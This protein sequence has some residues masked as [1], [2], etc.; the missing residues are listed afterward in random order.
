MTDI[1]QAP[2]GLAPIGP[3]THAPGHAARAVAAA[4]GIALGVVA[5][6]AVLLYLV[7]ALGGLGVVIAAVAA[8]I[9]FV[10]VLLTIRWIDRWEPEP[11]P[12]LVFAVLW[13]AGVAVAV[14]LLFD[15]GVQVVLAVAGGRP[16]DFAQAVV[17]APIV[18]EA[19]KG[20]GVLLLFWVNRRHF[21]GPVDGIVYAASI[22][23]GFAFTENILYFGRVI[24]E[25]GL[26]A[27]F[28]FTFVVRGIFSPFAHVLFT[29]CT[30]FAIGR[31]AER[32]GG[33]AAGFGAYVLGLIPAAFLHALWN[34]GLS[35]AGNVIEYYLLVEFPIFLGAVAVV[36]T[37]RARERAVTRARLGEYA[38]AGW[39][40]PQEVALISTPGG[41]RQ[42][43]RW[44]QAQPDPRRKRE[45]MIRLVRDATRLGHARQRLVKGRATIGR[46]P[47]EQELLARIT[48]DRA[49]LTS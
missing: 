31:I 34:G 17:Q 2:T 45:A 14:A 21:D 49:V 7:S 13:G 24:A 37:V 41:R 12:A 35:L 36:L 20:F 4:L 11:R 18:E 3:E 28:V 33:A 1:R 8:L 39:F 16:D 48:A 44:A 46:T 30:G 10:L 5:V 27:E 23:A 29:S 9:P 38:A 43:L 47:D 26:G 25:N 32:G 40:T 22:A 42:A 15:L 6:A 19:A